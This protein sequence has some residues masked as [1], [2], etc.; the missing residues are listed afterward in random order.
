MIAFPLVLAD[1]IMSST[2]KTETV[3]IGITPTEAA[4]AL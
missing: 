3:V 2:A 4:G 1:H